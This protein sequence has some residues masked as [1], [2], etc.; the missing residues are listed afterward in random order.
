MFKVIPFEFLLQMILSIHTL[1]NLS[2]MRGKKEKKKKKNC[3]KPGVVGGVGKQ[4]VSQDSQKFALSSLTC[5][6]AKA[7][8][9]ITSASFEDHSSCCKTKV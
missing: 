1:I 9:T 2:H 7:L 8:Q 6:I 5:V 4:C 3:G